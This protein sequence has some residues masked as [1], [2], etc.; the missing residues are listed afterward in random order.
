MATM[1]DKKQMLL[2]SEESLVFYR[3]CA[4][5]YCKTRYSQA[6]WEKI[7]YFT[8]ETID[9]QNVSPEI[10]VDN[11]WIEYQDFLSFE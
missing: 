3:H 10:W 7:K 11:Q 4:E 6:F 9:M 5:E 1:V 8:I 2:H